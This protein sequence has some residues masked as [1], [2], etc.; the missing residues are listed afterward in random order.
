MHGTGAARLRKRCFAKNL[1]F[2]A[3]DG[4]Y[5]V[6]A[7]LMSD[8]SDMPVC[9]TLFDGTDKT[10]TMYSVREFG[11]MCLLLSL[12]RALEYGE[13]LN[14][15]QADKRNR[16]MIRKEVPL[17]DADVH[18]EAVINAFVHNAW[19]DGN[20]PMTTVY[21]DHIKIMSHRTAYSHTPE[22]RQSLLDVCAGSNTASEEWWKNTLFGYEEMP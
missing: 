3:E 4:R 9:V 5:N 20:A 16:R 10:S 13:V 22:E 11:H 7:Q 17:F 2:L 8:N 6:F 18:R 21:S 19:I 15:P 14:V 12:S 1:G